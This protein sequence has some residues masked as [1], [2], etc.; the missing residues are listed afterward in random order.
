MSNRIFYAVQQVGIDGDQDNI[1]ETLYGVQSVSM[2]TSFNLDQAFQLGQLEIYENIEG[3]PNVEMNISRVLDGRPLAY[4]LAAGGY[5]NASNIVSASNNKSNLVLGIWDES[6][7][8]NAEGTPDNQVIISGALINSVSYNIGVDG[9]FTEDV[10]LIANDK[11]WYGYC[12]NASDW[13]NIYHNGSFSS[14]LSPEFEGGVQRREYLDLQSSIWPTI[15]PEASGRIQSISIN[16]D[17]NRE[18]IFVLGQKRPLDRKVNFPVEVTCSIDVL[19][20]GGDLVSAASE[21]CETGLTSCDLN[22]NLTNQEIKVV[23][24]D[25]TVIDLGN[26]NKLSSISY[27]GADAG[28]G[29]ATVTYDFVT[30]NKFSVSGSYNVIDFLPDFELTIQIVDSNGYALPL[31]EAGEYDFIVDWGDGSSDRI[32][33]YYDAENYHVYANTG[34]YSIKIRG[35]INGFNTQSFLY[36]NNRASGVAESFY[37]SSRLISINQFG[38]LQIKDDPLLIAGSGGITPGNYTFWRLS[39][40]TANDKPII[41]TNNLSYCFYRSSGVIS[42]NTSGLIT[43]IANWDVSNV[44]N[45]K[46]FARDAINFNDDIGNWNVSSA[47]NMESAFQNTSLDQDLSNWDIRNVNTFKDFL[48]GGQLSTDNYDNLLSGWTSLPILQ[49]NVTADFGNSQYTISKSSGYIDILTG[50]YGWTITDGG[51]I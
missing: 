29:N 9:N 7:H 17:F 24:C 23:L 36:P 43:G 38:C 14:G 37:I 2:S 5:E 3:V 19:T 33:S 48:T 16:L 31:M 47:T 26:K 51:G 15:I 39:A 30:Y 32:T 27:G 35:L 28:G 45:F 50:T 22:S 8:N 20:S 44:S 49:N 12:D 34:Y 25:G 18:D 40:L 11:A 46:A 42:F 1:Y 13:A 10:V 6:E 41:N 4:V 21:G